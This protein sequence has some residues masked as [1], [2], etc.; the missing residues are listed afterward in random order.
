MGGI[1]TGSW[2]TDIL[3]IFLILFSII[4]YIIA[5]DYNYWAKKGIPHIKPTFPVGNF[6]PALKMTRSCGQLF[7]DIYNSTTERFIGFYIFQ[8][9]FL[10]IRDPDLIKSVLVRDFTHFADKCHANN[11]DFDECGINN[12]F[13]IRTPHWKPMRSKLTPMFSALKL[14]TLFPLFRDVGDKLNTHLIAHNPTEKVNVKELTSRFSID[15][16]SSVAFGIETNSFLGK[17]TD[18]LEAAGTIT[19]FTVRRSLELTSFFFIPFFVRLFKFS[20]FGKE[21]TNMCRQVFNDAVK[22]RDETGFQ[23][24]DLVDVLMKIRDDEIKRREENASSE[25]SKYQ[26]HLTYCTHL[27]TNP[28]R[29][30]ER[31]RENDR[32]S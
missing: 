30:H 14:K 24:N 31:K 11:P 25:I 32:S 10:L 17:T 9:P 22:Y 7:Q 21:A 12:L 18:F 29:P 4:Y 23:R 13:N 19:K 3:T 27:D 5:K 1:L 15:V 26:S 2:L 8:R 20:F 28:S 16:I 6:W